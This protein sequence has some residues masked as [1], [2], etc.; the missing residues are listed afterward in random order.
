MHEEIVTPKEIGSCLPADP[1]H[2]V[3]DVPHPQH[4]VGRLLKEA[5]QAGNDIAFHAHVMVRAFHYFDH[6]HQEH[7][8]FR[9][10]VAKI[11]R[12]VLFQKVTLVLHRSR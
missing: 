6:A 1:F 9:Q 7:I 10:Q 4:Q 11:F 2:P 12:A 5:A 3:V 8:G